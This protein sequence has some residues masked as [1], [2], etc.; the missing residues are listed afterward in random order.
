MPFFKTTNNIFLD[1]GEHF[2]QNWMDSDK[3]VLPPSTP[4]KYEREMSI[5]DVDLWEVIVEANYSIYASWSPYAEFYMILPTV[6]AKYDGIELYY[7]P[8]SGEQVIKRA[9]ELNLPINKK[10]IWVENKDMWL[11]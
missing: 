4:W 6:N 7:G 3:L 5:E 9:K 11:Y 10:M 8:K 2:D 1:K